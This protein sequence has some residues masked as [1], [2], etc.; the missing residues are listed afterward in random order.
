M[1]KQIALHELNT[2]QPEIFQHSPPIDPCR[3]QM[4]SGVFRQAD[5]FADGRATIGPI[6]TP[7]EALVDSDV[8]GREIMQV[9]ERFRP[10][11]TQRERESSCTQVVPDLQPAAR[12]RHQIAFANVEYQ[13]CGWQYRARRIV[14]GS[15]GQRNQIQPVGI[16]RRGRSHGAHLNARGLNRFGSSH[17]A[18]VSEYSVRKGVEDRLKQNHRRPIRGAEESRRFIRSEQSMLARHSLVNQSTRPP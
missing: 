16:L 5:E 14:D 15:G 1:P 10:G 12:V 4:G 17:H 9:R 3:D 18:L 8:L 2:Q 13:I 11:S 7:N 6:D